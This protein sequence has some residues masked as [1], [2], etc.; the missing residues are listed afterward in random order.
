MD[1][2]LVIKYVE[3]GGMLCGILMVEETQEAII[4]V[5]SDVVYFLPYKYHEKAIK[6]KIAEYL[7]EQLLNIMGD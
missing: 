4:R 1:R 7:A 5:V 6:R 2:N 3:E